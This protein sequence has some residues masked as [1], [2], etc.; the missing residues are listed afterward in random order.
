MIFASYNETHMKDVTTIPVVL[1]V[2]VLSE[3]SDFV[4]LFVPV[5]AMHVCAGAH[6]LSDGDDGN[7]D[8][9]D[10]DSSRGDHAVAMIMIRLR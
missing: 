6:A 9:E 8:E 2:E 10:D 5:C 1:L 7:D 4:F 3:P